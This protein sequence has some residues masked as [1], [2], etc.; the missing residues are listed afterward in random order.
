MKF[1]YKFNNLLG[2]VYKKGNLLFSSNG[3]SVISPVANRINIFDLKNNKTVTLPIESR[4]N[5]TALDLSPNGCVLLAVN[6]EGEA[7]LISLI[8]QTV[9]HKYRFK[10]KVRCVKFSPNGNLFAVCKDN[11]V[12]VFRAPGQFSG[13][14]NAFIMERVFHT[15]TDETVCISWS[16]DSKFLAVGSKDMS[17]KIYSME[18]WTNFK[19]YSLRNH[20]DAIKGCFF[21]KDSYDMI[22]ISKNGQMNVWECTLNPDDL[23]PFDG[24]QPL[25]KEKPTDDLI[26]D[27]LDNSKSLEKTEKEIEDNLKNISLSDNTENNTKNKFNYKKLGRYYLADEV[28]KDDR[29]AVLT[30]VDYHNQTKILVIGFSN[31]SFYIYE[32]PEVNLIHS[33]NVSDQKISTLK[34][35]HSGDW[36]AM[37]CSNLGQLLVWEWQSE[38]YVL[39]QQGH[40]NNTSCLAYSIDGEFLATGGEDGKVKLWNVASGLCFVTFSEHT[41]AVNSVCFSGNKKFVVSA[42]VDG[43]VRAY[44]AVRYR[45]FRTFTGLRPV[46]F[47]SVAVD[48]SGE[49]VAAGAQDVFDIHLWSVKTGRLLEILSGHEGPVGSLAFSPL[50]TSSTLVSVSWDKTLRIWNAIERSSAHETIELTADGLCV[51]FNPNGEE[52]AVATLDG[53]ILVF[54]IKTATQLKSIEGRDDLGSGRSDTDLITAEKSKQSKAFTS[55]CYSADGEY[56]IAGGQSKNVCI[57]NVKEKLL[58][59]KF[60]I[61]QNRSLDAVDEFINRRKM[62]EFGNINLIEEREEKEGGKISIRLPGV[63]KGDMASRSFKPEIRLF[64]LQFSPTGQQWAAA[65]TEGILIYSLGTDIVFDPWDLQINITPDSVRK[66]LGQKEYA[67]ALIMSLK[68][69]E[70]SLINEVFESIPAVDVEL[71][72]KDL[73]QKYVEKL[74]QFLANLLEKSVHIEFYLN[75]IYSILSFHGLKLRNQKNMPAIM[76]LEKALI[77]KTQEIA[78][79]CD[80]NKYTIEYIRQLGEAISKKSKQEIK[81]ED[82]YSDYSADELLIGNFSE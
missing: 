31:G 74:M 81:T 7:H 60:E 27:E 72:V 20:T 61:T 2:A 18:K 50:P 42:S 8:S 82:D 36:I 55:L 44:D 80:H 23:I 78:K 66:S 57:Y 39:K 22:T 41:G 46:Q 49:F 54:H 45:N 26:E 11:N 52:V 13:Q 51:I 70:F 4:F 1:S 10:G 58:V 28:K 16:F 69:N 12:Y 63:Q 65:T 25:K 32:M 48:S 14:Y 21:E 33:L 5:Y 59:K 3:D 47:V 67:D 9:V 71:I 34:L 30:A 15:A 17:T 75:W 19:M 37:G 29:E 68:L 38:T 76:A 73:S 56:L 77:W 43:S 79:I 53:Q 6:E 64:C 62:T 40:S 24:V 35:N